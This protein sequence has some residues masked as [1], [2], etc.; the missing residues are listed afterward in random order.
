[1]NKRPNENTQVQN[2]ENRKRLKSLL[3]ESLTTPKKPSIFEGGTYTED[4]DLDR[5]D[6]LLKSDVLKRKGSPNTGEVSYLRELFNLTDE[7][8]QLSKLRAT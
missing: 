7:V 4:L 6:T 2:N 8:I 1:M 3:V 5:L